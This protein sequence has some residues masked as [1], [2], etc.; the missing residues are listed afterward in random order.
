MQA[1]RARKKLDDDE[2]EAEA[3][4]ARNFEPILHKLTIAT[5]APQ[6]DQAQ[7]KARELTDSAAFPFTVEIAS[8]DE[9]SEK[10]K[11]HPQV[12]AWHYPRNFG[13]QGEDKA[14]TQIVQDLLARYLRRC[15]WNPSLAREQI[16]TLSD[17]ILFGDY[18]RASFEQKAKVLKWA[19]RLSATDPEKLEQAKKLRTI[20][21]RLDNNAD[22]RYIDALIW[23]TEGDPDKAL[24]A[25]RD[26]SE[27]D[28][29]ATLFFI[30]QHSQG[31]EEALDWFSNQDHQSQPGWTTP[32]GWKNITLALSYKDRWEEA[33]DLLKPIGQSFPDWPDLS[34]IEG[35]IQS[36]LLL[37][38]EY[39]DHMLTLNLYHPDMRPI[40]GKAADQIRQYAIQCFERAIEYMKGEHPNRR[41]GAEERLL[42]LR[43][44][45][46]N[47]ETRREAQEQVQKDLLDP[48]QIP[49]RVPIALAFDIQFDKENVW[50]KLQGRQRLGG[51]EANEQ[52]AC[53]A[54]ARS[55]LSPQEMLTFMENQEQLLLKE[56]PKGVLIETRLESLLRMGKTT[57]AKQ[58]LDAE[59]ELF[60]DYDRIRIQTAIDYQEGKEGCEKLE[61][62]YSETR[63]LQDLQNLVR[64]LQAEKDWIALQSKLNELFERERTANNAIRLIHCMSRSNPAA[65][66]EILAF[67]IDNEDLIDREYQLK[68]AK[69]EALFLTGKLAEAKDLAEE[70]M[71][72][73]SNSQDLQLSIDI[74]LQRGAWDEFP[75]IVMR[76]WERRHAHPS[77]ILIQL[78]ALAAETDST[79]NRALELISLAIEKAENEPKI[80]AQAIGMAF[81]LGKEGEELRQWVAKATELSSLPEKES[82][83][84]RVDM[85][86]LVEE[87][88][89]AHQEWEQ[90]IETLWREGSLP[91][92]VV[93]SSLNIPLFRLLHSIPLANSKSEDARRRVILPIFSG[94][95]SPA[96]LSSDW[97][98]GLDITSIIM[99]YHFSILDKVAQAF[100][101]I[102]LAP[103]TMVVLL[104]E[105]NQVRFH[106]PSRIR[107]AKKVCSLIDDQQLNEVSEI[108]DSP[109]KNEV[110]S[111]LDHLLQK[112]SEM[113]GFV[114]SPKS[115]H[116][117][118][119]FG[120]LVADLG[121]LDKRIMTTVDLENLLFD[122]GYLDNLEHETA[123]SF[124]Q[125]QD[126]KG[127]QK[128]FRDS[129]SKP[130]FLTDLAISYLYTAGILE[131]LCATQLDLWTHPNLRIANRTLIKGAQSGTKLSHDINEIRVV[132]QQ[133][134]DEGRAIFTSRNHPGDD[135]EKRIYKNAPTLLQ[136]LQDSKPCDAFCGED[137]LS[138]GQGMFIDKNG[139]EIPLITI[140]DLLDHLEDR[141]ILSTDI[142][143]S[144]LS[145][146]RRA[147]F[148]LLPLEPDE[149]ITHLQ[150]ASCDEEH[151][152]QETAELRNIRQSLA[153]IRNIDL[154]QIPQ[155]IAYLEHLL[156]THILTIRRLWSD[157]S[158]PATKAR[159]IARWVML[160]LP[161]PYDYLSK[162]DYS[163]DHLH[164]AWTYYLNM[165]T[166]PMK[167]DDDR[168]RQYLEWFEQEIIQDLVP[169]SFA[170]LEQ[171]LESQKDRIATIMN[172]IG[173]SENSA[174]FLQF[175]LQSLP[176]IISEKIHNDK[177]FF[178]K[179]PGPTRSLLNLGDLVTIDREELFQA[180]QK[181]YS[182]SRVET[183]YSP[184]A[185]NVSLEITA[186][187]EFQLQVLD[188]NNNTFQITGLDILMLFSP[189][190]RE[191]TQ[192]FQS[193]F[194]HFGPADRDMTE[195]EHIIERRAISPEELTNLHKIFQD[196]ICTW[197][198]QFREQLHESTLTFE[199]LV[200]KSWSYFEK[201]CGPYPQDAEPEEYLTSILVS[202]RRQ[203]LQRDLPGGLEICLWGC[204]R[205]DL[206]PGLWLEDISDDEIWE[207]LE[208]LQPQQDP[209]SLLGALDLALYRCHDERF[210]SFADK[211]INKLGQPQ[212][213]HPDAVDLY[214][215]L[216]VLAEFNLGNLQ[217]LPDG[218]LHPPFWKRLCAWMHANFILHAMHD[219]SVNLDDLISGLHQ[220]ISPVSIL[221][222]LMD[223][224]RE[225]KIKASEMTREVLR[226]EILGRLELIWKRH[227]EA[228]QARDQIQ[229]LETAITNLNTPTN[230]IFGFFP[231]PLEGH[232]TTT[233]LETNASEIDKQVQRI[234]REGWH[235][236]LVGWSQLATLSAESI[237][238]LKER[239]QFLKPN[240]ELIPG[241]ERLPRLL[242]A[243]FV[244]AVGR[245]ED[246]AHEIGAVISA[247]VS[248]LESE[249]IQTVLQI[250]MVTS[251]AFENDLKWS[252]W[253]EQQLVHVAGRVTSKDAKVV[254][255][256]LHVLK[257]ALPCEDRGLLVRAEALTTS[258]Y[259][260]TQ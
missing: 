27:P 76:E 184:T 198:Q 122:S 254:L 19:S 11:R 22:L 221:A 121:E 247:I 33:A 244:A 243:S 233:F 125:S 213:L 36:A 163:Q 59:G 108:E 242:D 83:L 185:E 166:L 107:F 182:G 192:G 165:L 180:A 103:D 85:R 4:A 10:L 66:P 188:G 15:S 12:V 200:P 48:R 186:D 143:Y 194:S 208:N 164:S 255:A 252:A 90:H 120:K 171:F 93:A 239:I 223:L 44:T 67:L 80:L 2:I 37:P 197:Q 225:P 133:A 218:I 88:M 24:R 18:D 216:P 183:I 118:G 205:D 250:L 168:F 124:L 49:F 137:R 234:L 173:S 156:E 211:A 127:T 190:P 176:K 160:N 3:E 139:R 60:N 77:H 45:A 94:K 1:K 87:W 232:I 152:L 193:M 46:A 167:I 74:A 57:Q 70:L 31:L 246:L 248:D 241:D 147:G 69:G 81:R 154:M 23:A 260:V 95:K 209:F 20:L 100:N 135:T 150:S 17:N 174:L 204:L 146:M 227:R 224:R 235:Q 219:V 117:V 82:P 142:R 16:L 189:E 129:L 161:T 203:L 138:R 144:I 115:I 212:F 7:K 187:Q 8:W 25:I 259:A 40:E 29:R 89:P 34:F 128:F 58:I 231:G 123:H 177:A 32:L 55:L 65:A 54:L 110:G 151:D 51:L 159:A 79:A 30:L 52:K 119:S 206:C 47:P 229:A 14:H 71:Q 131:K 64:C 196:G 86:T 72:E 106:Q 62:I 257:L 13:V 102:V 41:K 201:F 136:F 96:K 230:P 5:T 210:Q 215:L 153:R 112:A 251:A 238:L 228:D 78:A 195:W 245:H 28:A 92:S 43:L 105:R 207:A 75:N 35:T 157:E 39:R 132:L 56:I 181:I 99:L 63:D 256:W 220:N 237:S 98:I 191:R 140:L 258:A 26:I 42:W 141:G 158:I 113:D 53:F 84:Q 134:I 179:L 149:L 114:V 155:E 6:D 162:F 199:D 9:I 111:E 130:L 253:L 91:I 214:K 202:Y 104:N 148:A 61:E 101:Q 236:T 169:A 226:A 50:A 249:K 145:R 126:F 97:R 172:N 178:S 68:S 170:I 73:R 21:R 240:N 116:K 175:L 109:L 217:E 222:K 38:K